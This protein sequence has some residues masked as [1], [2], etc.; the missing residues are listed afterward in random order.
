MAANN[1]HLGKRFIFFS[2]PQLCNYPSY[3]AFKNK[4]DEM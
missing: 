3:V 4:I 1:W 2:N